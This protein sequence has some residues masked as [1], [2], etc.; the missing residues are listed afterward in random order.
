MGAPP[1][2]KIDYS[3]NP[4]ANSHGPV[5]ARPTSSTPAH[6][7]SSGAEAIEIA[8]RL[9]EKFRAGSALRDREGLLRV[10][11]LDEYAESG[12]WSINVPN[13]Y[14]GPEVSYA[15]LMQQ[16][17][18]IRRKRRLLRHRSPSRRPRG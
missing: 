1:D 17:R 10:A 5:A 3:A 18:K 4:R 13:A 16:R 9:A 8:A 6:V 14:G 2:A 7:V 12:L 11:E 15:T